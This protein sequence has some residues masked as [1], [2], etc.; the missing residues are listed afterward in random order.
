MAQPTLEQIEAAKKHANNV[1]AYADM[2]FP[3]VL[4]TMLN[5]SRNTLQTE[6]NV[7]AQR[8]LR[9]GICRAAADI[10]ITAGKEFLSKWKER[11]GEFVA[12]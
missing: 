11:K 10:S 2:V 3:Q 5:A 4:S 9:V 6:H 1:K 7:E 12:T 8:A